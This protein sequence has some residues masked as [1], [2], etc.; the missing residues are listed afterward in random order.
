ME[1]A[2]VNAYRGNFSWSLAH[3]NSNFEVVD[4][5]REFGEFNPSFL[6]DA[7]VYYLAHIQA[8]TGGL[9]QDRSRI[10]P[11]IIKDKCSQ[12]SMLYHNG[13]IKQHY[14]DKHNYEGWDTSL[15][16]RLVY[17]CDLFDIN[18]LNEV[19]GSF[20]CALIAEGNHMNLFRNQSSPMF[21]NSLG[22]ISST[23]CKIVG[24]STK[25]DIVYEFNPFIEQKLKEI[26]QFSNI[27]KPF[28][29]RG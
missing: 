7:S 29:I 27:N 17:G 4:L 1:L 14:L 11:S 25:C 10:H 20:S 16:H 28:Y 22:D 5:Q 18:Y 6:D 19:D 12:T 15:L 26:I 24:D 9:I 8:P 13:I 21:I 23:R 3:I 2:K